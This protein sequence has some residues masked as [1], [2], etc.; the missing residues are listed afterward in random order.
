MSGIDSIQRRV[1]RGTVRARTKAAYSV[2]YEARLPEA[3]RPA[4]GARAF[5]VNFVDKGRAPFVYQGDDVDEA[6]ERIN[7]ACK[8]PPAVSAEEAA[9]RRPPPLID[10][11]GGPDPRPVPCGLPN[12]VMTREEQ[13]HV[14]ERISPT[15][16]MPDDEWHGD[17]CCKPGE[18]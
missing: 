12:V 4:R 10:C 8:R 1:Y 3:S 2:D 15:P 17:E 7:R 11:M 5:R 16:R 6:V 18:S 13:R 14:L 9:R